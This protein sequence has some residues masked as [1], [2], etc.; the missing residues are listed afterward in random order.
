MIGNEI[1]VGQVVKVV[2]KDSKFKGMLG[3]VEKGIGLNRLE[4]RLEN[5][6]ARPYARRSLQRMEF[7]HRNAKWVPAGAVPQAIPKAPPP[8]EPPKKVPDQ[9]FM[10]CRDPNDFD[11]VKNMHGNYQTP[12]PPRA[13][14]KTAAEAEEVAVGMAKKGKAKFVVLQTYV[15]F[16]VN[17]KL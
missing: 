9:F 14:Y 10:V 3:S 5:G 12:A 8:V 2:G 1:K 17:R 7:D 15:S 4:V 6:E 11:M 16:D 13:I